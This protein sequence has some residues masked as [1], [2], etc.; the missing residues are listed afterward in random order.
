MRR[1]LLPV[2]AAATLATPAAAQ[3]RDGAVAFRLRPETFERARAY[4]GRNAGSEQTER[5]SRK[6]RIG[7][8]GRVTIS[9]ISGNIVVTG[10]SGDE[11]SIDAIKHARGGSAQLGN[12]RI[13]VEE[14][15]GGVYVRTTH[16]GSN[17]RV[18]VDYTVTMPASA[19][20]DAHSVSGD[21]KVTGVRGA[22]RV[23]A[24]SGNVTAT[25]TPK[26]E[27]ARSVSGDVLL[28]GVTT[29]GDLVAASISGNVT[30]RSIKVRSLELGSVSGDL[31]AVDVTCDRLSAKSTSGEV[32]YTGA[33]TK[34][35]SY[36]IN[37]HSGDVRLTLANPSGFVLNANTFSGSI[38]S[39][40]QLTIGGDAGAGSPQG[41][42]SFSN[43]SMR[44]TYGDGS[45][46][47][48]VRTFSGD[49]IISK[50]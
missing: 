49:I 50:R 39:D 15:G 41:R 12:V 4:Q 25:D 36:D 29:D 21:V 37:V 34:G 5:F 7:A 40:L 1:T 13:D 22:V 3:S 48:T 9:N 19:S 26:L 24:V 31:K 38:R 32:E 47:L 33:I 43:R 20:I 23:D 35:G 27:N 18:S 45:A 17:D 2:L 11:V 16:T 6:V 8:D 28:S 44:A 42:R 46:T 10:G 14:R 30:A